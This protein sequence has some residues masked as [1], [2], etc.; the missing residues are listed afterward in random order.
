MLKSKF[1]LFRWDLKKSFM[2]YAYT[3]SQRTKCLE[4]Y[5]G[6][7]T[8]K[9]IW[10]TLSQTVLIV[11]NITGSCIQVTEI[12]T[13]FNLGELYT[14]VPR[15]TRTAS[16]SRIRECTTKYARHLWVPHNYKDRQI[17]GV[18]VKL[19]K[20]VLCD[21]NGLSTLSKRKDVKKR[22][23]LFIAFFYLWL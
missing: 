6:F 20:S 12:N 18:F 22:P 11:A 1:Y 3:K 10:K 4:W 16:G 17:A 13:C 14:R 7:V 9:N 23:V 5:I 8:P 2:V 15:S 19:V 21:E